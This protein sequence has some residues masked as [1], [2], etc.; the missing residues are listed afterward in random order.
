[1]TNN[2]IIYVRVSNENQEIENQE[3]QCKEYAE[4]HG[5]SVVKV[6]KEL[7]PASDKV[8]PIFKEMLK[9]VHINNIPNL[10]FLKSDRA[11][12]NNADYTTLKNMARNENFNIHFIKNDFCMNKNTFI[13][14]EV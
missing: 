3:L 11:S 1:M 6:F 9:F 7:S 10:I 14:I 4:K 13:G 8:R 5:L 2:A 12:R